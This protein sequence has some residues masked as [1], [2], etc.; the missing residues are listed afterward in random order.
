MPIELRE[1]H[2]RVQVP[3]ASEEPASGFP[4]GVFVDNSGALWTGP[5]DTTPDEL[6]AGKTDESQAAN[7]GHEKWIEVESMTWGSG[8]AAAPDA[9][10]HETP[11]VSDFSITK[12]SDHETPFYL[13]L[14][15]VDGDIDANVPA[16]RQAI[17]KMLTAGY[18]LGD[19]DNALFADGGVRADGADGVGGLIYSGESGGMDAS[20]YGQFGGGVFVAAGDL[21]GHGPFLLSAQF[22]L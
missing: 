22:L 19:D 14:Q 1:L 20:I 6:G 3:D 9:S 2:I 4:G 18:A 5:G 13:K 21:E 16:E 15:G 11:P 10:T 8:A 17:L 7:S 12:Q